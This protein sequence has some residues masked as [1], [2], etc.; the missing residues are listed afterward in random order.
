[1]EA[2]NFSDVID[3][4]LRLMEEQNAVREAIVIKNGNISI[5]ARSM[6]YEIPLE[7]CE[8]VEGALEWLRNMSE[9]DWVTKAM[10]WRI[11]ECMMIHN[12][13]M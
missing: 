6:V 9:K 13:E 11:A 4:S 3:D 2:R 10:L 8:S 7:E 1:M 12:R 5:H